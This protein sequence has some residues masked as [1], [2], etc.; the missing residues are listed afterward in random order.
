M[1][2]LT[3]PKMLLI[4]LFGYEAL[5]VSAVFHFADPRHNARRMGHGE[6]QSVKCQIGIEEYRD[7]RDP[8]KF[9]G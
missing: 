9:W 2:N 8:R 7:L 5:V 4:S 1:A 3:C 6:H